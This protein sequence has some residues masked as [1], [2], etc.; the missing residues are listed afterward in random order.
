VQKPCLLPKTSDLLLKLQGFKH[1]LSMLANEC[2]E[3]LQTPN[4]PSDK[5]INNQNTRMEVVRGL[6]G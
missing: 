6:P 5:S 4:S 2:P 1:H 3:G